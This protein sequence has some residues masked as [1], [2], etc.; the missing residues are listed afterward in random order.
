[1]VLNLI[2]VFTPKLV[3]PQAIIPAITANDSP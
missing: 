3:T 2:R 1:M